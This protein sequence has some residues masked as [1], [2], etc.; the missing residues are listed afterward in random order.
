MKST[1][2][3]PKHGVVQQHLR[4]ISLLLNDSVFVKPRSGYV[5]KMGS[6]RSTIVRNYYL[7]TSYNTLD[8]QM[9][10][11]PRESDTINI[12][13]VDIYPRAY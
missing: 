10:S 12:S 11:L 8:L 4:I 3:T 1:T 2:G 6:H 5:V 13:Y 9:P 7:E